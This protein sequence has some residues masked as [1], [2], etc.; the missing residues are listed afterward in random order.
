MQ[1]IIKPYPFYDRT[2]KWSFSLA[3]MQDLISTELYVTPSSNKL[4]VICSTTLQ[5]LEA[6]TSQRQN[7]TWRRI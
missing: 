1:V 5:H 3:N 2:N 7:H 4:H 6:G